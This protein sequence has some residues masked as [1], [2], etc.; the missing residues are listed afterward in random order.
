MF[1]ST[2][3]HGLEKAGTGS[4]DALGFEP[5]DLGQADS[6]FALQHLSIVLAQGRRRCAM[7]VPSRP[8]KIA[9]NAGYRVSP[10]KGCF[11]V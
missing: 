2:T 4:D 5:I 3:D 6:E 8:E 1:L 7:E 11:I 9:G 10:V